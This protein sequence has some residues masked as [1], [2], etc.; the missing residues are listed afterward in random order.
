MY[1][2]PHKTENKTKINKYVNGLRKSRTVNR[3]NIIRE[4]VVTHKNP[5]CENLER[6]REIEK[7]TKK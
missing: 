4:C 6:D 7:G 5:K 3:V 1:A 2:V